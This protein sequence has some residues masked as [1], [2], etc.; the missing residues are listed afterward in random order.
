M[1]R[2]PRTANRPKQAPGGQP[3]AAA[4][5]G[6]SQGSLSP[7]EVLQGP[8][9]RSAQRAPPASPRKQAGG[10][11][12][13]RM[14][15]HAQ[16]IVHLLDE[17]WFGAQP[18]VSETADDEAEVVPPLPPLRRGRRQ[19][20]PQQAGEGGQ[21]DADASPTTSG[22]HRSGSA[23]GSQASG[24]QASGGS[25]LPRGTM[26]QPILSMRQAQQV[27]A[28]QDLPGIGTWAGR[29]RLFGR[30]QP[31]A[32][33]PAPEASQQPQQGGAEVQQ[34]DSARKREAEE[35]YDQFGSP[36]VLRPGGFDQ[37]A[38]RRSSGGS[39]GSE[40]ARED[41]WRWRFSRK[42]ATEQMKYHEGGEPASM[43]SDDLDPLAFTQ[44]CGIGMGLQLLQTSAPH[45]RPAL[46]EA[47]GL[48][49]QPRGLET[50]T[51]NLSLLTD[52]ASYQ[53]G[54]LGAE[55]SPGPSTHGAAAAGQLLQRTTS[56]SSAAALDPG[57]EGQQAQPRQP[58]RSNT[59]A[60][61]GASP[62]N[63]LAATRSVLTLANKAQDLLQK[64]RAIE[65]AE[66]DRWDRSRT[67]EDAWAG[68]HLQAARIDM[69]GRFKFCVLRVSDGAGHTRFVVRGR[70]G[71]TSATLLAE[72][73]AEA[74][75]ASRSAGASPATV[76]VVG[77]GVMEWRED[78][79]RHL[80]VMPSTLPSDGRAGGGGSP[81]KVPSSFLGDV[82]GLAASL[83]RQALPCHFR[84]TTAASASRSASMAALNNRI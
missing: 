54:L 20:H 22:S 10:V 81:T 47:A 56:S 55:M 38:G 66:Q 31:P 33:Q 17:G 68:R 53:P 8:W 24:S 19:Q 29:Y 62:L 75:A 58:R 69:R 16:D 25:A 72:V 41:A 50:S 34:P 11:Q 82:C 15:G 49:V 76:E 84:I 27:A 32:D 80:H 73:K 3:P 43:A 14:E 52:E 37:P 51:S 57:G 78:T 42:W 44:A 67:A 71:A 13:A 1:L 36:V 26:P 5:Q 61:Q 35:A 59:W 40:Q 39:Y 9:T 64:Q 12:P 2:L 77:D 63:G 23:E 48:D 4:G 60:A 7:T 21:R 70:A 65:Q 79:E 18:P 74:A 45:Q 6:G 30:D 46:A 83:A 28:I